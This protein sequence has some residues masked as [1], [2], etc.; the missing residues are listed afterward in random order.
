MKRFLMTLSCAALFALP[1]L[2]QQPPKDPPKDAENPLVTRMMAFDKNKDGKLTKDEVTDER[3]LRLFTQADT[4][5]DGVVTKEELV[6]LAGREGGGEQPRP[7]TGGPGGP[8]GG[9]GGPGGFPGGF[10]G[11]PRIEP[12]TVLPPFLKDQLELTADQEKKLDELEKDVKAKLMKILSDD[13]KKKLDE[14]G[15]RGPFGPGGPGGSGGGPGG[16]PGGPGGGRPPM[17]QRP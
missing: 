2:A 4:N 14:M 12:G 11:L 10:P 17:P 5:K 13:Q 8:G 7:G 15:R 3:L 16:G 1:V 9:P 6:A